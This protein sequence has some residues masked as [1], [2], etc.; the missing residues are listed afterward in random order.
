MLDSV[1][2]LVEMAC[3]YLLLYV[4]M[5]FFLPAFSTISIYP[6]FCNVFS[7]ALLTSA[8]VSKSD[9]ITPSFSIKNSNALICLSDLIVLLSISCCIFSASFFFKYT[10]FAFFS[11]TL[12]STTFCSSS[13]WQH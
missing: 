3:L 4:K 12:F 13:R 9:I 5:D 6:F 10:K 8:N 2:H 11:F 1:R 7:T